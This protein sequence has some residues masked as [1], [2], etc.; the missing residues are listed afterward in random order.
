MSADG[1][2]RCLEAMCRRVEAI[3]DSGE[4]PSE[5]VE[6]LLV[7]V[8]GLRVAEEELRQQNEKLTV[9]HLSVEEERQRYQQLFHYA[10]DAYLLTDLYGI[11]RE[12]N[13]SAA[14]L[15][16][17]EPRFMPGKALVSFVAIEDRPRIRAELS[18]WLS[19]PTPKS[20]EAR[21]QPLGGAAFDASVTLSVARGGPRDTAI[22]F[23]WLIRDTSAQRQLTDELRHREESARREVDASE[24]RA[25]HVQKLESIGVLAG[26]IA[27]DFNNLLHVVLGNADLA[28]LHLAAD[29]MA[30]EHLDEVVRATQRA[31]DLAQQLLAYSGRGAVETRQLDL[32]C[33]VRELAT[34]LRTALTK[35]GTLVWELAVDLPAITADPTQI[36]QVVMNLITNASDSLGEGAG[37]IALRTGT[38]ADGDEVPGP[39]QFVYLEVVDNGCGMDT[40]TLQRIFDPF[41]STKFTGRGLG[42]SAVMGIVESHGGHIRIR[43]APAEG[44]TFRVLFPATAGDAN[45]P[46]RRIS[47]ADWRGHGTVLVIE[48]EDEVREVVGRMLERLGFHVIAAQDGVAALERLDEH[49][50]SVAAVLLDLSMPRMGGYEVLQRIRGRKPDLP[51]ILMSGYTEQEVASKVLDARSG[52]VGFLQKP[53]LPEDLTSVLRHVSPPAQV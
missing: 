18:R 32:S 4:V 52:V 37:T 47:G 21:L 27:H 19:E 10:P 25:R 30:R 45:A 6:A 31:A 26:G 13:R 22:G 51:V 44:T 7:A 49:D 40:G 3:R 43:T 16:G 36:R 17:V 48:D 11:V 41:F 5:A 24:A 1:V 8:E 20:L 35:Q 23:R 46:P 15:L 2:V 12:A 29:S 28:R 39:G 42:L 50:G 53:F 34:L 9:T 33:E 14:R 38:V